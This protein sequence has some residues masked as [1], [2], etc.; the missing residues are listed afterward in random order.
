MGGGAS[1]TIWVG[2]DAFHVRIDGPADGPALMFCNSLSS[3]LSMWDDQ[4][5]ELSTRFR[6]IRYDGRGHGKSVASPGPY[7][8]DQLGRD[9]VGILDALGVARAHWCG[10]SLGGM[11]GMWMLTH[12]RE[13]I[14][15]AVL[16]NTAA[17]MGPASLWDGRIAAAREGGMEALV[18]A[19]ITRW[20]P[21]DFRERAPQTME[22][23]RAMILGTPPEGFQACCFAIRDMDQRE[24]IQSISNPT[25]VIIGSRDPAT[26]PADGELIH[27]RVPG[28]QK[29]VLDA[30]HISNVEQAAAFTG[31]LT[32]FL[33]EA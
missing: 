29:L 16:A 21:A 28:S 5:P 14:G 32:R 7:T 13:R 19:T 27:E 17:Y 23:M 22:R 15:R 25:L 12:A 31:A 24:D 30:A 3:D 26:T 1:E 18:D 2:G 10:V 11:V 4:V 20:F 8:M 33:L 6:I 9:A